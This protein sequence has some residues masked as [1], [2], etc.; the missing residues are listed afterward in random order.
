MAASHQDNSFLFLKLQIKVEKKRQITS[1]AKS[2][3]AHIDWS[4]ANKSR[5]RGP[6]KINL[7]NNA[8]R[9]QQLYNS[10]N[11]K[12]N[13]THSQ[14]KSSQG[15][16]ASQTATKSASVT[17][18][19]RKSELLSPN[20]RFI[21]PPPSV[22]IQSTD[23]SIRDNEYQLQEEEV[24]SVPLH[25]HNYKFIA[26]P[27]DENVQTTTATKQSPVHIQQ[28]IVTSVP[29]AIS[30][31]PRID[32]T[33]PSQAQIVYQHQTSV[34][35]LKNTTPTAVIAKSNVM[36][37]NS[38]HSNGPSHSTSQFTSHKNS[39]V[40]SSTTVAPTSTT[41]TTT[42]TSQR[43]PPK[44]NI[45][46]QQT[47]TKSNINFVPL[48]DNK[49][50]IKSDSKLANAFKTQKIQ[51]IPGQISTLASSSSTHS[52]NKMQPQNNFIIRGTSHQHTIH[53]KVFSVP[54][55]SN[56][57]NAQA[58]YVNMPSTQSPT[59]NVTIPADAM[60]TIEKV[61]AEEAP[62][63]IITTDTDDY[64]IDET[65]GTTYELVEQNV[66]DTAAYVTTTTKI[67]PIPAKRAKLSNNEN[68]NH[69]NRQRTSF[70]TPKLMSNASQQY[71]THVT[72]N[73][74]VSTII[75]EEHPATDW[76]YELDYAQD[77]KSNGNGQ[78]IVTTDHDGEV[79]VENDTTEYHD[80]NIIYTEE[81]IIDDE[82][83]LQEEYVTTEVFSPDGKT[84]T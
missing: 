37:E 6:N 52:A 59:S 56:H 39:I 21:E 60:H 30:N 83:V 73:E 36:V 25:S 15:S 20:V 13:T 22:A 42:T 79:V 58:F 76:E 84:I 75:Y 5:K 2:K 3:P 47:I 82:N 9:I 26:T 66:G 45:L 4:T 32:A 81:E 23:H 50:I 74:I 24:N 19:R 33:R 41:T 53:P 11:S 63:E 69:D 44:I 46:S 64:I 10:H 12:A 29:N 43:I 8:T 40:M 35:K 48:T 57:Q 31:L 77:G 7:P 55:N 1:P 27:N 18:R 14:R 38:N 80:A 67:E 65:T 34:P 54:L 62:I 61:I 72:N 68:R 70:V 71:R 78:T 17:N 16:T 49:I 28:T 51:M